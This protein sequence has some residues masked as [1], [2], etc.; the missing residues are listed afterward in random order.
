MRNARVTLFGKR[1][2]WVWGRNGKLSLV[3]DY[4]GRALERFSR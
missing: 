1:Y 4:W 2:A 3:P